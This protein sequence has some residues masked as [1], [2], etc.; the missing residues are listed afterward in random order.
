MS[1]LL[2][3]HGPHPTSRAHPRCAR[4]PALHGA[5]TA[6]IALSSAVLTACSVEDL[7]SVEAAD[8]EVGPTTN[9]QRDLLRTDLDIDLESHSAVAKVS[10][11]ASEAAGASLEVGDL[12]IAAVSDAEGPVPY[13]ID[14]GRL[15]LGLPADQ[16]AEVEIQYNFQTRRK[17]EGATEGGLTFLWPY[18]CGNLFPCKSDPADGLQLSLSLRGVPDGSQAIFPTAIP[19]DAPSYML[20][21]S[22]GDY[23]R[24]ELG[25]TSAGTK[26][27]VFYLP[28]QQSQAT[29]G[30]AH[31]VAAFDWLERTYG[32]YLYGDEVGSVSAPWGPGA[33]GGMEHHPYWHVSA[34]SLGDEETHIHEAIHGWFGD[35]VRL[36]C[37]EDLTLSEGTTC[38]VTARALGA[39]KGAEAEASLWASYDT[40]LNRVISYQDRVARPEGCGEI[41]V[42]TELWN[43]VPYM[44]GAFFYRAVEQQI[45]REAMDAVLAQF[46]ATYAT[47]AASMSDMIATIADVTGFDA[48]ELADGWLHS[49]DRPDRD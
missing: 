45:G 49:L 36:R 28:G 24:M 14:G 38:Y 13:T 39:V 1:C 12:T 8:T 48:T 20:A 3:G 46:Y 11:A 33:Y 22:V 31:L 15:D 32:A 44:K 42:L 43:Q 47:Q 37:W 19:A 23:T 4:H 35:G 29:S 30:T 26:V 21:W 16:P 27:A 40:R 6:V 9:W 2:L 7:G 17:L 5:L 25:A 41:D 10:L 18:F 34:D